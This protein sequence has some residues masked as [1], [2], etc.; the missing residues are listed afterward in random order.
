MTT[1]PQRTLRND[2][3]DVLRR[4]EAGER[5]TITVAGRAVAELGPV[6]TI[7]PQ[8]VVPGH[9]IRELFND[10]PPDEALLD[11]LRDVGGGVVDPFE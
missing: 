7:G 1:I 11:D 9:V 10:L 6:P 4:A 2:I 5:F 3:G 8:R